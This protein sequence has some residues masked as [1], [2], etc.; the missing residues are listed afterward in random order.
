MVLSKHVLRILTYVRTIGKTRTITS[1][2][3][4]RHG[5]CDIGWIDS[6]IHDMT[7]LTAQIAR[8]NF[9]GR[10]TFSRQRRLHRFALIL[11]ANVS[12]VR[13]GH[14]NARNPIGSGT[15]AF[16]Y[17]APAPTPAAV[18]FWCFATV[19]KISR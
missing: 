15:A 14:F 2:L 9:H 11:N 6:C 3:K 16:V 8:G 1:Y 7:F 10:E 13:A 18:Q 12:P 19:G 17:F 5:R 4:Q